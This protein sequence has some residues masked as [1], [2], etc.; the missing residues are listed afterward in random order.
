MYSINP[1][2]EHNV[3]KY[4]EQNVPQ[5]QRS[6]C[7]QLCALPLALET[8]RFSGLE[9]RLCLLC[10]LGEIENE[11]HFMFYCP[12]YDA[13]RDVVFSKMSLLFDC[14]FHL[15]EYEKFELRFGEGTFHTANYIYEAWEMKKNTLYLWFEFCMQHF[16]HTMHH[17]MSVSYEPTRA[18]Q[19]EYKA[20]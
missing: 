12:L 18:G 10:N 3:E 5:N 1:Q 9:Q 15:D 16:V 8:G 11:I 14:F 2:K 13:L 7:A 4:V 17:C 20:L 19:H 6:L